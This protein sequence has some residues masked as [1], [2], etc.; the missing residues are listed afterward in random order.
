MG[1][2]SIGEIIPMKTSG[3]VGW[4]YGLQ[5]EL[6]SGSIQLQESFATNRG[7]RIII[8]NRT[9]TYPTALDSGVDV[10]TGFSTNIGITRSF[11]RHLPPPYTNCLSTDIT[12]IDWNQNEVLKFMYE[13]FVMGQFYI[14]GDGVTYPYAGNWTWNWTVSY[15]QSVCVKQCF[16]KYLFEQCSCYDVTLPRSPFVTDLYLRTACVK[17]ASIDCLNTAQQKFYSDSS[18]SGECYHKCPVE[19]EEVKFDLTIST[20]SYPTEWYAHVLANNSKFNEVINMYFDAINL[21]HVNYTDDFVGLKKTIARV[22][23]YYE[24]LR[25]TEVIESP[26]LTAILLLGTLGGNLGRKFLCYSYLVITESV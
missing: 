24:D 17:R 23:I 18:L 25:Y 8:I 12:K 9:N 26:A 1:R 10:L 21:P 11:T 4:R 16:Q 22:N 19:C 2:S 7:F 13:N 6:Y 14:S 15:S 20:S 5:M 3:Q